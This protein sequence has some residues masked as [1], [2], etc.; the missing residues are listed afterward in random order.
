MLSRQTC[1]LRS[2]LLAFQSHLHPLALLPYGGSSPS[3][4][5]EP[6]PC[7]CGLAALPYLQGIALDQPKSTS[8]LHT[9]P[10]EPAG[11]PN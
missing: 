5:E 8:C 2:A 11:D 4:K 3:P 10:K 1:F 7:P 6:L 9:P